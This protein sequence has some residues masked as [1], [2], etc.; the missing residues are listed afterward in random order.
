MCVVTCLGNSLH[1]LPTTVNDVRAI[2]TVT[3]H[4]LEGTPGGPDTDDLQDLQELQDLQNG[5]SQ[6]WS[7]TTNSDGCDNTIV[8]L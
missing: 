1:F 3:S 6:A 8:L 5:K 2:N 7:H 4:L